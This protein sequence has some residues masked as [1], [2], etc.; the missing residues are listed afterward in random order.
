MG[1]KVE[2]VSQDSADL[3]QKYQKT[4]LEAEVGYWELELATMTLS[5]DEGYRRL[6][7]KEEGLYQSFLSADFNEIH[8]D[9]RPKLIEYFNRVLIDDSK[10]SANYRIR[11]KK[12]DVKYVRLCATRNKVDGKL[13]SVSGV[14]W[15]FTSETLLQ[16]ELTVAKEFTENVLDAIPAPVFVKNEKYE[17]IYGNSEFQKFIDMPREKFIGKTDY[18][19][20]PKTVADLFRKTDIE[21]FE[22]DISLEFEHTASNARGE[23]RDLYSKKSLIKLPLNKKY[24]VGAALDITE[25]KKVQKSL[26]KQ[27][28]MASLGEMAAEI[29]HEVNNPLMIIQGKA[30]ILIGKLKSQKF[31]LESIQKDLEQIE[32]NCVR[33]DKIIKSLKSVT[34]K[35]DLDPFENVSMLSLVDEAFQISFVRFSK[36]NLSLIISCDSQ[37]NVKSQISGRPSEIVQVLVNLLNNSYDAIQDQ[38]SGWAKINVTSKK[39]FYLIEVTDS[40]PEIQPDIAQKMMEP[41][42]TTKSAGKGT[43]LG[44]SVSKQIIRN[45]GGELY[46][47]PARPHTCF[48]FTIPK[49]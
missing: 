14:C 10:I 39:S 36:K 2:S 49:K 47:D 12:Q 18:E 46:Y 3:F 30:Q 34:R 42:Y 19:I 17:T 27:S 23:P 37:I 29:A 13:V 7:E 32:T 4:L 44:L 8:E 26:V 1:L 31:D 48:V 11:S 16:R 24:L 9:Y 45:H 33:I 38:E 41:F 5:W 43:G 35:A 21:V 6:F 25:L 20:Y 22:K 28:K 15:D 40:G